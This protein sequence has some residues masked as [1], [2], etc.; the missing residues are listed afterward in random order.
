MWNDN[1]DWLNM[2][3]IDTFPFCSLDS[4]YLINE[5]VVYT[6]WSGKRIETLNVHY[7][8]CCSKQIVTYR[9]LSMCTTIQ[10]DSTNY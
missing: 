4:G 9:Y 2:K 10:N 5:V 1:F 7:Q 8:L 6:K 3:L